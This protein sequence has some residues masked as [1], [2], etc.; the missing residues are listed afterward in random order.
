MNRRQF[1][2]LAA[3]A[4]VLTPAAALA[5]SPV[6]NALAD[7]RRTAEDKDRDAR[8]KP[9]EVVAFAHIKSGSKVAD[10][11]IGGGYYSRVFAS[12]VGPRGKV[13]SW[14]P[15]EFVSF[16]ADY[17]KPLTELPVAFPNVSTSGASFAEFAPPGGLDVAFTNQNYHDFHLP[18]FPADTAA[19]VNA[20]VFAALKPGGYYVI[21]DHSA[22]SGA[23]VGT[24]ANTLHRI[25]IDAVKREVM[26]AGFVLDGSSDLLRNPADPRT[27]IVFDPGIRGHTDQF[28]LRFKKPRFSMFNRHAPT[29][30]DQ[31]P[32]MIH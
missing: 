7:S 23:D 18:P 5:W 8:S 9:A 16:S 17:A 10:L 6:S 12:V 27:A 14:Q 15:A 20:A 3:A 26:A 24:T 1:G 22:V 32:G 29:P 21:I 28:M 30:S 19:K 31:T 25:D 13:W 4:L 11:V 2:L